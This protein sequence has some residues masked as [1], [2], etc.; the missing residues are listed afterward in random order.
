LS[1]IWPRLEHNDDEGDTGTAVITKARPSLK[2]PAMYKVLLHNDDF[3]PMD[4]VVEILE[5][6]FS[7]DATESQK[8][9]LEVHTKGIGLCGIYPKEIAETKAILVSEKARENQFPL[10]CT[11]EKDS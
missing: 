3:T 4:F 2:E 8:I 10:K 7:K 9:M 5:Q 6:Y 11:F 1:N